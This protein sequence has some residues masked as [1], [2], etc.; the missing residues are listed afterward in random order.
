MKTFDATSSSGLMMNGFMADRIARRSARAI[1]KVCAPLYI[2]ADDC[3]SA[4]MQTTPLAARLSRLL[5]LL[6]AAAMFSSCESLPLTKH[7]GVTHVAVVWLKR[8]GNP[9]DQSKL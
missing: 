3:F 6:L 5:F 8:H 1:Q 4:A 2:V 7:K 9:D